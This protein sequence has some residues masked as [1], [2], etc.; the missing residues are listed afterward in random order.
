MSNFP[1]R[2][3]DLLSRLKTPLA[4]GLVSLAS[5]GAVFSTA[6]CASGSPEQVAGHIEP[7]APTGDI[8]DTDI[9]KTL[10][11]VGT[12]LEATMQALPVGKYPYSTNKQGD[13]NLRVGPS[14]WVAGFFPGSLWLMYAETG[15]DKWK[16][17]AEAWTKPLSSH[18]VAKDHREVGLVMIPAPGNGFELTD[19]PDYKQTLLESAAALDARFNPKIGAFGSDV[20]TPEGKRF[21]MI[22]DNTMNLELMFWAAKNGGDPNY[23]AHSTQHTLTAIKNL[24]RPDGSVFQDV[25]FDDSGKAVK[26]FNKQGYSDTSV[27]SRGQAWAIAGFATAYRATENPE[28]LAAAEKVSDY[29]IDN[30]PPD[31]VPP[32]DFDAPNIPNAPR[33]SSAAAIA[34]SGLL[35]LSAS[36]PDQAKQE[37]YFGAA[38]AILKS[39]MSRRYLA[40]GGQAVLKHATQFERVSSNTGLVE[41]DYYFTQSLIRYKELVASKAGSSNT[42]LT[43]LGF[44]LVK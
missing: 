41:G 33:D 1:P 31:H 8:P 29:F 11:D 9:N 6:G 42:N 19:R 27:W 28:I 38:E 20:N 17:A 2:A 18:A 14:G 39:L 35:E 7:F 21:R 23:L 40:K 3:E 16:Q 37:K 24:V 26:H 25:L 32:W 15:Q 10:K 34:A 36:E 22:I 44:G 13:W 12:H 30:L 43:K 4:V 5:A